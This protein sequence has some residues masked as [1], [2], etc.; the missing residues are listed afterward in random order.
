MTTTTKYGEYTLLT[1]DATA[2]TF[3]EYVVGALGDHSEDYDTAALTDAY[4]AALNEQ[5]PTGV[6]LVGD[7]VFGPY[8]VDAALCEQI[9]A[10]WDAVDFWAIAEKHDRTA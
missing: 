6:T 4:R 5:L 2:Q 3:T 10:A 8:P 7:E 1:E 9:P